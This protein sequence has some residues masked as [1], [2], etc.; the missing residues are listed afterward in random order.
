[1]QQLDLADASVDGVVCRFGYMLV[2]D[3]DAPLAR[4]AA[5]LR[6]GGRSRSPSGLP[7]T[8]PLGDGVRA[9]GDRARAQEPPKPGR[10]RPVS[11]SRTRN[12]ALV[13]RRGLRRGHVDEV[14]SRVA[15]SLDDGG[16][17]RGD[18]SRLAARAARRR[19]RTRP[20]GPRST[21]GPSVRRLEC[22]R[23]GDGYARARRRARDER[24][25][26]DRL[27]ERARDELD[28]EQ[29]R[30]VLAVEDR[31]HLDDLERAGEARLRDELEARCA[32]R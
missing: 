1:M 24:A 21:P 12:R 9:G 15:A 29:R 18:S 23:G 11:R 22:V 30:R 25:L 4:P 10:A 6:P 28:R 31:V 19:F 7:A 17:R 16:R 8:Q 2:P 32:S 13:A 3:M 27:A 5:S 14:P 26:E 20:R